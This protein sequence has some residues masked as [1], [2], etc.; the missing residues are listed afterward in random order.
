MALDTYN[1]VYP[2]QYFE[3]GT[4]YA[5]YKTRS[6]AN[7]RAAT[8]EEISK[9]ASALDKT[10]QDNQRL[11]TAG[12]SP[13][14]SQIERAIGVVI[15][16]NP[17]ESNLGKATLDVLF[18]DNNGEYFITKYIAEGVSVAL[19]DKE[20]V[21]PGTTVSSGT[22]AKEY[23]VSKTSSNKQREKSKS[24]QA[25]PAGPTAV[26]PAGPTEVKPAGP[27]EVRTAGPTEV[28]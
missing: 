25:K 1:S 24:S 7:C 21:I 16:K 11:V 14:N 19:N 15:G 3:I 6:M 17:I 22:S 9:Y 5:F 23:V 28:K 12:S 10:Y 4:C 8:S 2:G 26:K 27:T 20:N 18:Q 13:Y